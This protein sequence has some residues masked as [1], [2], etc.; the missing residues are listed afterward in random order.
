MTM[1]HVLAPP[2][3]FEGP[4]QH[5]VLGGVQ[6][7]H[8]VSHAVQPASSGS[9]NPPHLCTSIANARPRAPGRRGVA[10][11][12]AVAL[13]VHGVAVLGV[14]SRSGPNGRGDFSAAALAGGRARSRRGCGGVAGAALAARADLEGAHALPAARQPAGRVPGRSC[15]CHR[16]AVKHLRPAVTLT[17]S[18]LSG[19]PSPGSRDGG[20]AVS[21]TISGLGPDPRG[22][23]A[24]LIQQICSVQQ[25]VRMAPGQS[26]PLS[27]G[28]ASPPGDMPSGSQGRSHSPPARHG[29]R[30][31]R[32]VRGALGEGILAAGLAVVLRVARAFGSGR[33][34][35]G[36]RLDERRQGTR[37]ALRAARGQGLPGTGRARRARLHGRRA[38]TAAAR[39]DGTRPHDDLVSA[40][41]GPLKRLH[42]EQGSAWCRHGQHS[43]AAARA[44]PRQRARRQRRRPATPR[45]RPR[46]RARRPP[47]PQRLRLPR[48]HVRRVS[49]GSRRIHRSTRWHADTSGPHALAQER[50]CRPASMETLAGVGAGRG[51]DP[52][53]P[54]AGPLSPWPWW[55]RPMTPQE[56]PPCK[57]TAA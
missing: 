38:R 4:P 24:V 3:R 25:S 22:D 15:A 9:P 49:L 23:S 8:A 28:P 30:A 5:R 42:I 14:R 54:P 12:P 56:Q 43:P 29:L 7:S 34:R 40:R 1:P 20:H 18:R 32:Q 6:V 11:G 10:A 37:H 26:T 45:G 19:C 39:S 33:G 35:R 57:C 36:L 55:R 41:R 16:A 17:A 52:A 46:R 50:L 27:S 53:G 31:W 13:H 48:A 2:T 47:R 51:V 44:R 21:S